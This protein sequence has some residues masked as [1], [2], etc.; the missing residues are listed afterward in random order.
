MLEVTGAAETFR[1]NLSV[2]ERRWPR[3]ARAL[4]EADGDLTIE[5][6]P[7][8]AGEPT[9]KVRR[10]KGDLYYHSRYDPASE[11]IA[12]A[13]AHDVRAADVV[14]C[15]GVGL[16]YHVEEVTSCLKPEGSL[17]L[18]ELSREVL[19]A[20][21][22]C[23]DRSRLLSDRRVHLFSAGAT[24]NDIEQACRA[25]LSPARYHQRSWLYLGWPPALRLLPSGYDQFR[26]QVRSV[27]DKATAV[28]GTTLS[29]GAL[30]AENGW[31]NLKHALAS[32]PVRSLQGAFRSLP[33]VIVASGPSLEE[34]IGFLKHLRGRAVVCATG[35]AYPLLCREGITPHIVVAA[36]ALPDNLS[37]FDGV[38]SDETFLVYDP[39]IHPPILD[40]G[41]ER[42][43]VCQA[44]EEGYNPVLKLLNR[45]FGEVGRLRSLYSVST[46]C[47]SLGLFC[48]AELVI[49]IGQDLGFLKGRSHAL[50]TAFCEEVALNTQARGNGGR[51]KMV[52]TTGWYEGDY[53]ELA[54][55]DGGLIHSHK[56]WVHTLQ[57][58]E[59]MVASSRV[60]CVNTSAH[61]ARISGAP[62][63]SFDEVEQML[64]ASFDARAIISHCWRPLLAHRRKLSRLRQLLE[65]EIHRLEDLARRAS[66]CRQDTADLLS[67][68]VAGGLAASAQERL[69]RISA[70]GFMVEKHPAMGWIGPWGYEVQNFLLKS[71]GSPADTDEKTWH[72]NRM[73]VFFQGVE[74]AADNALGAMRGALADLSLLEAKEAAYA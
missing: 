16:G 3:I 43:I 46:T 11:G 12:F 14:I 30:W 61:G 7:S 33:W 56:G 1:R 38:G 18:V 69:A 49:L 28:Q 55:N 63:T 54:S 15:L 67:R 52:S 66:R 72:V 48:G 4:T 50:G 57:A 36:D 60:R 65:S 64:G 23:A 13:N 68:M 42:Q 41:V 53:Y 26:Q 9:L 2:V 47:L 39:M 58:L 27:V 40:R 8:Q 6:V 73:G 74:E 34:G 70:E 25:Y 19:R 45:V 31:R 44:Q 51:G 10:Q 22:T 29:F 59:E 17:W 35:S 24:G 71:K 20:F 37:H 32:A 62:Y 5:M 21:L